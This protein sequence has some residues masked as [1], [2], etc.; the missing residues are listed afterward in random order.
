MLLMIG[1][2]IGHG[3]GSNYHL[4][5]RMPSYWLETAGFHVKSC[6]SNHAK[7]RVE[8]IERLIWARNSDI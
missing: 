8:E 4:P 7:C 3:H 2:I 5:E 1:Q 6:V